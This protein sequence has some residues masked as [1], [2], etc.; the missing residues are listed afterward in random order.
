MDTFLTFLNLTILLIYTDEYTGIF[1]LIRTF[2][3]FLVTVLNMRLSRWLSRS[4][5]AVYRL[6]TGRLFAGMF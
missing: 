5:L 1:P 2:L 6:L 4:R 3:N